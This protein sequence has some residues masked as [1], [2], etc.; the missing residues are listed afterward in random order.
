MALLVLW[1]DESVSESVSNIFF[2][3]RGDLGLGSERLR[4]RPCFFFF[5]GVMGSLLRI[6]LLR[7]LLLALLRLELAERS[8]LLEWLL[9]AI[10]SMSGVLGGEE[11]EL[12][13]LSVN[14]VLLFFGDLM[15][16]ASSFGCRGCSSNFSCVGQ[17]SLGGL[18]P[19]V[20]VF[21]PQCASVLIG[22][23]AFLPFIVVVVVV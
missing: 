18:L 2:R 21:F 23:G 11:E 9:V 12:F 4:R 17:L 22:Q 14:F 5:M 13:S 16:G 7:V 10:I 20:G 6:L 15:A 8:D 3:G 19:R 1:T